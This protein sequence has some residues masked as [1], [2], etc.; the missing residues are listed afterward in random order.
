MKGIL[1]M[2]DH[3]KIPEMIIA[4]VPA[5]PEANLQIA[6]IKKADYYSAFFVLMDIL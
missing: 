1:K 3:T 5:V 4:E 6:E 2:M